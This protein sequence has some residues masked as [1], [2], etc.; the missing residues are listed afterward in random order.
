MDKGWSWALV[1]GVV[2]GLVALG[3]ARVVVWQGRNRSVQP[4]ATV[5][6]PASQQRAQPTGGARVA[7]APV[8]N[9]NPEQAA[10]ALIQNLYQSLS[11]KIGS[12][13]V[14][15][16]HLLCKANVT[17]QNLQVIERRAGKWQFLGRNTYFYP[18]GDTQEE[19]RSYT[20]IWHNG[21]PLI[22]D[23]QFIRVIKPR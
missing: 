8:L 19:E 15:P 11:E 4:K 13:L 10:I 5:S 17:V 7:T 23:S 21:Q 16:T 1:G 14:W 22:S 12:K 18:N 20:V 9:P 6:T 3:V 2:G